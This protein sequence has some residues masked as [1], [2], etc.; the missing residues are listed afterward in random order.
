MPNNL[1]FLKSESV[2]KSIRNMLSVASNIIAKDEPVHFITVIKRSQ[3][4]HPEIL[5][6]KSFL[7]GA[8]DFSSDLISHADHLRE[9]A[10]KQFEDATQPSPQYTQIAKTDIVFCS[11]CGAKKG[12]VLVLCAGL[13]PSL[14]NVF[15]KALHKTILQMAALDYS[16]IKLEAQK[17]R[18]SN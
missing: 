15:A 7:G 9:I 12:K 3:N 11:Y 14:C 6:E 4:I 13:R 17:E 8:V 10:I 5:L 18:F 16:L 2:E 1:D